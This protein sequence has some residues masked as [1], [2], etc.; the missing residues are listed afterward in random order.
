MSKAGRPKMIDWNSDCRVC[1]TCPEK[2]A[3][4]LENFHKDASRPNGR[5]S[6][7]KACLMVNRKPNVKAKARETIKSVIRHP[8]TR[9][10]IAMLTGYDEDV[11]SDVLA[12]LWDAGEAR[13]ERGVF[14]AA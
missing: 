5:M 6:R 1:P 11:V 4:P 10:E 12:R 9:E 13:V 14:I 8:R 2:G 7:C 3:Q